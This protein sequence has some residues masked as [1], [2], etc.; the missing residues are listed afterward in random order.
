M[1]VYTDIFSGEEIISDSFKFEYKF[2][3]VGVQIKSAYI[4]KAE[5]DIDIGCGNAFGGTGEEEGKADAEK[6]LD[7]VD[8]FKYQETS[9]GKKD[10]TTYIKGYMKKVKTYLEEKNPDRVAGFMKGAGEMVKWILENF[11]EFTFYTPESYDTENS[12]ILSYYNGEEATPT[13]VYFIDGLKG[14]VV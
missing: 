1:K 11:D 10:Y 14:M 4:L 13:F 12:I 5:G 2:E 9:F 3:N 7:V 6:V 8:A